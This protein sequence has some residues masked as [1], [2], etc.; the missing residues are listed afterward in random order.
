M[1]DKICYA[2]NVPDFKIL[3]LTPNLVVSDSDQDYYN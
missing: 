3:R 1:N 2:K